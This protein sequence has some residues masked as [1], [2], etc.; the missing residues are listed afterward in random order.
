M[1]LRSLTVRD[2]RCYD[3]SHFEFS[4]GINFIYGLN[5]RG[6]TTLLEAIY[7]LMTGRSFRALQLKDLI[8]TDAP[9]FHV[10]A[11]F[12]KHEIEQL[13]KFSYNGQERRIAHNSSTSSLTSSLLGI[14]QGV[15]LT[16]DDAGLIKGSPAGRRH[17]LDLQI[18]QVDPLYVHHLTRYQKAMRQ[19]NVL[20]KAKSCNSI[21]GWEIELANSG[22]YII[23]QRRRVTEELQI[24]IR[25][26]HRA[27]HE[28]DE[29]F[30]IRY[31]STVDAGA[32]ASID[33]IRRYLIEQYR[34]LRTRELMLGS[35]LVGPHKDD[36]EISLQRK[37]ARYF[38]S[39]GQQRSCVITLRLAEWT[40]L[41]Q[42]S[43]ECPLMLLDDVGM[44]LDVGR[45][46][47]L[48]DHLQ[49]LGQVFI[50]STDE[51]PM[52]NNSKEIRSIYINP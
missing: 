3:E 26:L 29:S 28:S 19:R 41:K 17:F 15:T 24:H 7:L 46:A 30:E 9:L 36:L 48:F 45:R 35:T 10:E 20:L 4:P 31:R 44:S 39:E 27:V 22:A 12:I 33:E 34:R 5:A 25:E 40:R 23:Q 32:V 2:F 11:Q 1:H 21:E 52:Q 51:I 37:D 50:T 43:I 18:A 8:R 47:R 49:Q 14:L 16:P 42:F 6:K 13:L 38:A